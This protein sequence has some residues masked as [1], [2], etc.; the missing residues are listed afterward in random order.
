MKYWDTLNTMNIETDDD[1][2]HLNHTLATDNTRRF[3][4]V[5]DNI[6]GIVCHT[7][8]LSSVVVLVSF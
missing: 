8:D 4:H 6:F 3:R 1:K 5:R 2:V 7:L